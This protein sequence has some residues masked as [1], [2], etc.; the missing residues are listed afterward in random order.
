M[1]VSENG[2]PA[3]LQGDRVSRVKK[4]ADGAWDQQAAQ[5]GENSMFFKPRDK[6][7]KV[8]F[9]DR[10]S[11]TGICIAQGG[12]FGDPKSRKTPVLYVSNWVYPQGGSI[13][14]YK[15]IGKSFDKAVPLSQ[16]KG[17]RFI[18]GA[19]GADLLIGPDGHMYL[20][21]T[22]VGESNGGWNPIWR[23]VRK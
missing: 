1:F 16:D 3:V 11:V 8:L 18:T 14:R 10:P 21:A 22:G 12:V 2:G 5:S 20:S 9:R 13:S 23:I 7:H 4:G 6:K 17:Q 19:Q 15:L